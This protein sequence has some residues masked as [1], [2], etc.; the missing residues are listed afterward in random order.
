MNGPSIPWRT[1]SHN[2]R[3][4]WGHQ[5]RKSSPG[6]KKGQLKV[7]AKAQVEYLG[8]APSSG[9]ESKEGHTSVAWV[10]SDMTRLPIF[11]YIYS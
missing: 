3:V 2:H 4:Y 5:V 1:V 7:A 8:L 11:P 6:R 9:W 10:K